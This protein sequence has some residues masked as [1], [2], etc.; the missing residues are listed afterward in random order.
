M[1]LRR[2]FSERSKYRGRDGVVR[3]HNRLDFAAFSANTIHDQWPNQMPRKS[4][5]IKGNEAALASAGLS[6]H[7]KIVALNWRAG[8]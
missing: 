5:N 6:A 7:K 1:R 3:V 8:K 4:A 2:A